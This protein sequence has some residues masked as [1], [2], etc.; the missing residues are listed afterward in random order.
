MHTTTETTAI[1]DDGLRVLVTGPGVPFNLASIRTLPSV[2]PHADA[3]TPQLPL[4]D[5]GFGTNSAGFNLT[6]KGALI[7]R[8]TNT[9]NSTI[10]RAA[11]LGAAFAVVY[12]YSSNTSLPGAPGGEQL[13][14]M[15]GTDY[16][17]IPAVFIGHSDGEAL[18][19]LF[20]TNNAALA[21]IHL[22]STSIVFNVNETLMCE[23]VGLR[24]ISDHPLRGDVRITLVSPSGVRSVLQRFNAD[25]TP[26]PVDWTYYSTHHFFESSAGTWTAYFSDEYTGAEGSV[27]L[28]SLSLSGVALDDTDADALDDIWELA[29]FGDLNQSPKTDPDRDGYSNARE[30]LMGTPPNLPGERF[31]LDFSRWNQ[32]LARLSWPG[33]PHYTYEIRAGTNVAALNVLTN[34][35][36]SWPET[37]WFT[38]YKTVDRQFFQRARHTC[39]LGAR[40]GSAVL[41]NVS[42]GHAHVL[43][44]PK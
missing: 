27:Y 31:P 12:N 18:K 37:E 36:G 43:L 6:N 39:P 7:Q 8:S 26:G 11:Q 5:F 16:V 25:E 17:P 28:A 9:F 23:H 24:V 3:P 44:A 4:V 22:N 40:S 10:T 29:Y 42:I 41:K 20:Q 32:T 13:I 34:I 38:P 21:Q 19:A 33:S 1:P 14:P 35:P 2:G 15:G 30:Q